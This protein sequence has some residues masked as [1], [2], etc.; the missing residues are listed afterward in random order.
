MR[1]VHVRGTRGVEQILAAARRQ[2]R[3][4]R[5]T[6]PKVKRERVDHADALRWQLKVLGIEHR[7][8][9]RFHVERMWRLDVAFPEAR[10]AVEVEGFAAG[11]TAGRHQRIVGFREDIQKYAALCCAGWRL[12]RVTGK[13]IA[14]GKAVE[15]IQASLSIGSEL[16]PPR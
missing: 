8:E 7:G 4:P 12:L 3:E 16:P 15:W 5:A 13:E 6:K 11:G 10:L 9:Y 1:Q 2:G 14:N